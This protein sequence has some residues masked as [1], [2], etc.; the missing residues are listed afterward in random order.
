[1][2]FNSAFKGLLVCQKLAFADMTNDWN[3]DVWTHRS[4]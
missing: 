3:G 1:M 4:K 2:G